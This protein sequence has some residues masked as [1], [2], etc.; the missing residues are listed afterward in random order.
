MHNFSWTNDIALLIMA[1]KLLLQSHCP[2]VY[3]SPCIVY[4]LCR[5][6][7]IPYFVST[8][9][10][11]NWCFHPVPMLIAWMCVTNSLDVCQHATS[12][13]QLSTYC[14]QSISKVVLESD[15]FE[16]SIAFMK[17]YEPIQQSQIHYSIACGQQNSWHCKKLGTAPRT[18]LHWGP[19]NANYCN[20]LF[21]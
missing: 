14:S 5:V 19:C 9:T 15:P 12:I 3:L 18:L 8:D 1:N 4:Q 7:R 6:R 11:R 17:F 20:I 13:P 10:Q 21:Q 2:I 16:N